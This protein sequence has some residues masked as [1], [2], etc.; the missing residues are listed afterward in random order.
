M[1]TYVHEGGKKLGNMLPESVA[2]SMQTHTPEQDKSD[3]RKVA[4]EGWSQLTHA[5]KGLATAVGT[6]GVAVSENTHKAVEHG[7]GKEADKVA[8]GQY[9]TLQASAQSYRTDE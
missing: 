2:K 8:Q 1:G 4:E 3:F 5:A 9:Y 7:F 6:V